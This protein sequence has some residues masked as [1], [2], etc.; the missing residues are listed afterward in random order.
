MR[1]NQQHE[2]ELLTDNEYRTRVFC[3]AC[4]LADTHGTMFIVINDCDDVLLFSFVAFYFSHISFTSFELQLGTL[5]RGTCLS[6]MVGSR[7]SASAP[8]ICLYKYQ[9]KSPP[10]F[11][12]KS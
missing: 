3:L 10:K 8:H 4:Y 12:E 6:T 9:P 11:A 7:G 1:Q 2:P 5:K